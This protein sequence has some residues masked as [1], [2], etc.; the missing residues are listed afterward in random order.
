MGLTGAQPLFYHRVHSPIRHCEQVLNTL[1]NVVP[2]EPHTHIDI[3]LA[4]FLWLRQHG[5]ECKDSK[6][7]GTR[8]LHILQHLSTV[9]KRPWQVCNAGK[10]KCERL[11][12]EHWASVTRIKLQGAGVGFLVGGS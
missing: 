1:L 5:R 2:G 8:I 10:N 11:P 12:P 3:A 7:V 4:W 9:V 6:T